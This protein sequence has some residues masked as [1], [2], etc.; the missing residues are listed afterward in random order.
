MGWSSWNTFGINISESIIKGQA[1]AMVS[2]GFSSVGYKY[3][4]IDDGFFGGRNTETGELLIHPQRFP[5]GLK[6]VC[7]NGT[8][9]GKQ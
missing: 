5:N 6:V 3:I 8:I 1:D 2:Q 4:N 7:I 9:N